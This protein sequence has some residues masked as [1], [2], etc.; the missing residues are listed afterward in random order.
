MENIDKLL[1]ELK[2]LVELDNKRKEASRKRGENYNI[3]SVLK[4]ESA[5]METHSA[6]LASLLNPNGDHGVKNAFLE[7]FIRSMSMEDLDIDAANCT[8]SVEFYTGNGRLDILM[9]DNTAHKAVIIEN[10][11]YA[12]DQEAQ[13]KRY[14]DYAIANF[15]GGFRL[16]Y[17]TLD[18]HCPSEKSLQGL[19]ETAF[20]CISYRD[21][22]LPWLEQCAQIAFNKPVVRETINQY[23]TL[24]RNLTGM[25]SE[26]DIK[27]DII[28]LMSTEENFQAAAL[29]AYN[30]REIKKRIVYENLKPQLKEKIKAV[31]GCNILDENFKFGEGPYSSIRIGVASWQQAV[32]R[33]EFEKYNGTDGLIYGIHWP[34]GRPANIKI[35]GFKLNNNWAWHNFPEPYFWWGE[36]TFKDIFNGKVAEAFI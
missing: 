24:I 1:S 20:T 17:L 23:I 13:I 3:F 36:N 32:I 12:G 22:I 34:K 10:K 25:N 11:I 15:K 21:N 35:N 5:E 2:H 6:F 9:A 28:K 8:V 14:H 31:Q 33:F 19:P 16:F 7:E 29:V 27:N 26:E 4:M 30:F 18:G